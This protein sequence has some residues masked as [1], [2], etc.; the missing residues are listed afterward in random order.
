MDLDK[1][2]SLITSGKLF[3]TRACH[4]EDTWEG[5]TSPRNIDTA[6][7]DE[8][9]DNS[10]NKSPD[11]QAIKRMGITTVQ[12]RLKNAIFASSL[13]VDL[14]YRYAISC[15]SMHCHDT[16]FLWKVYSSTKNGIAIQT[17]FGRL[18]A[19]FCNESR[20]VHVGKV[21]YM[22]YEKT[23]L[24]FGN[25]FSNIM[26]KRNCY[27]YENEIRA[28]VW[29]GEAIPPSHEARAFYSEKGE[30]VSIDI[31]SL[32]EA[33]YLSPQSGTSFGDAINSIVAKYGYAIPVLK[34]R[35]LEPPKHLTSIRQI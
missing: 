19:A 10:I 25:A 32:A 18:K 27:A 2:L 28:V 7:L 34:S 12:Q 35:L 33:I 23:A 11:L 13:D 3:F 24:P 5:V 16:D 29:E 30:L 14:R 8:I 4:F 17:T 6:V 1:F 22:D 9:V 21:T 31:N 20:N 15:W 26:H